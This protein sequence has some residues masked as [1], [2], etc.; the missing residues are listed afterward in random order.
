MFDFTFLSER[1]LPIIT[2][3][4]SSIYELLCAILWEKNRFFFF[5]P[6]DHINIECQRFT[7]RERHQNHIPHHSIHSDFLTDFFSISFF[8]FVATI[9]R[10]RLLSL[11][12]FLLL[13]GMTD[14]FLTDSIDVKDL[15]NPQIPAMHY[16]TILRIRL[17][18]V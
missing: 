11:Y 3:Q 5:L 18:R 9:L 16:S 7:M 15:F 10:L 4:R 2:K 17:T 14:I 8:C 1:F 12:S 6:F 13:K